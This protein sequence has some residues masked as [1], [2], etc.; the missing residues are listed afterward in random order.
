MLPFPDCVARLVFR[1]LGLPEMLRWGLVAGAVRSWHVAVERFA[2]VA[3][4]PRAFRPTFTALV[5]R[6]GGRCQLCLQTVR[7]KPGGAFALKCHLRCIRPYIIPTRRLRIQDDE[8][9]ACKYTARRTDPADGEFRQRL[10]RLSVPCG[11]AFSGYRWYHAALFWD[12]GGKRCCESD[13][14][15]EI[16]PGPKRRKMSMAAA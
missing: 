14:M 8:V 16:V 10:R 13:R 6:V 5:R 1:H 12:R 2:S 7:A 11:V 4:W 15:E 3:E 9:V